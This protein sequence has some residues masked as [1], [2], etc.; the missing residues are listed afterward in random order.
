VRINWQSFA[1][2]R[3]RLPPC[4][5]VYFIGAPFNIGYPRSPSR[6]VLA[7]VAADLRAELRALF[8]QPA[9]SNDLLAAVLKDATLPSV[10][11]VALPTLSASAVDAVALAVLSRFVER[12]GTL[13]YANSA[14]G[15]TRVGDAW[16]GELDLVEPA[17][18]RLPT[19]D[20][21]AIGA[22]YGLQWKED[23]LPPLGLAFTLRA[24]DQAAG[25]MEVS[26]EDT[27]FAWRSVTFSR[28]VP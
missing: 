18:K 25:D 3:A 23:A 4:A 20:A 15:V 6:I 12:H 16:D 1:D 8:K 10:S 13:P 24:S 19:L 9:R 14:G 7:N 28:A 22:R 11:L 27:G 5:G 26:R 2:L 21:N 17:G